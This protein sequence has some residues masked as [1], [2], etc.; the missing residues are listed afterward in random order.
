MGITLFI[1]VT[2][3]YHIFAS[4]VMLNHFSSQLNRFLHLFFGQ[5][6]AFHAEADAGAV[7]ATLPAQAD[8][9]LHVPFK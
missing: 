5:D 8:A 1:I 3:A 4:L 9:A 2:I 7:Q 6:R